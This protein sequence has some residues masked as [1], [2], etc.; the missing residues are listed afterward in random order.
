[1]DT[2]QVDTAVGELLGLVVRTRF[3]NP[4]TSADPYTDTL[5]LWVS[6]ITEV[7]KILA[8]LEVPA[9]TLSEIESIYRESVEAWLRGDEP[10]CDYADDDATARLMDDED[11][12][13]RFREAIDPP[14][15]WIA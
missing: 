9:S 14:N 11:L 3:R 7:R 5:V 4:G 10:K 13:H 1:M 6:S 15:V 2:Q 8:P 12:E